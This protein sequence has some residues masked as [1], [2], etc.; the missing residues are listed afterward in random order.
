MAPL[1]TDYEA[2]QQDEVEALR[3]IYMDD[4]KEQQ[5]KTAWNV[6]ATPPAVHSF[7]ILVQA[8]SLWVIKSWPPNR[9]CV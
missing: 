8:G 6:G 3:S 4:F 7:S 5:K 2:I 1:A 9:R